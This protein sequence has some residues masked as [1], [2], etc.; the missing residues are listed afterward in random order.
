MKL[1]HLDDGDDTSWHGSLRD[2]R[3]A[4][5]R[6]PPVFRGAIRIAEIHVRADKASLLHMQNAKG[7]IEDRRGRTWKLATRGA[8]ELIHQP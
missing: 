7:P 8:L 4:G 3:I 6:T 1:Y 2:A 5:K